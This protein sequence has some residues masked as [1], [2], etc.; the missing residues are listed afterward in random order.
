VGLRLGDDEGEVMVREAVLRILT[1]D[2]EY[3]DAWDL[4]TTVFH[5]DDIWRRADRALA[6]HPADPVAVERR[7]GIAVALDDFALADSLA[8]QVLAA[9]RP[10][11]PAYLIRAEADFG[12]GWDSAGYA[13]YDSA[14]THA[15][16]DSTG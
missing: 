10:Y 1:L 15:D 16:I 14:L 11:L 8:G 13:W 9:R 2:P 4:F 6:L 7:A 12:A 3:R 5:D